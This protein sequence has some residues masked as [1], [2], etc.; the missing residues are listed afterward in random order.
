MLLVGGTSSLQGGVEQFCERA[1]KALSSA[2]RH[3]V[4]H[5]PTNASYLRPRSLPAFLSSIGSLVRRR[6]DGWHCVWLQYVSFPDLC[7]LLVC[8]VL[9]YKVLVTPHLGSSWVS[10]TNPVLRYLGMRMFSTANGVALISDSQADELSLPK[11]LSVFHVLTFLPSK[12][13]GQRSLP[14]GAGPLRLVHA[15]RL[16][17][18]KGSFLFVEACALLRQ[19]QLEFRAQL[20][21]SCDEETAA[22]LR[23]LISERNLAGHVEFL[24]SLPEA[25]LL[26]ELSSADVLVHLS[27]V[28]SFPLIVL[29]SIAC[30]VFPICWDLPGARQITQSY[31]GHIVRGP[32]E[33]EQVARFLIG[34]DRDE[35]N[36]SA[37]SAGRRLRVDYDWQNCVAACDAA[38]AS[39]AGKALA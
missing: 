31:C 30:G 17:K 10:Q 29:E 18:G 38:F 35:L 25:E 20:I 4:L 36:R 37:A 23:G 15:A 3:E 13:P 5:V 12:F 1:A 6:R 24:G 34:Q 14:D 28:D 19:A 8:R 7:V 26:R 9:G 27:K 11:Y 32:G 22:T 21:G 39:V 33:A 16:S 2:G